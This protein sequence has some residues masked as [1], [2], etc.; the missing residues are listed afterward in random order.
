MGKFK[1]KI[2]GIL[3]WE[4]S[5]ALLLKPG[6]KYRVQA[7]VEAEN[8]EP[9]NIAVKE[10]EIQLQATP[11]SPQENRV[12]LATT[13]ITTAIIPDI[14]PHRDHWVSNFVS[15]EQHGGQ[16]YYKLIEQG[17][18]YRGNLIESVDPIFTA[19]D[20]G[21]SFCGLF[22]HLNPQQPDA[23]NFFP[24]IQGS[25]YAR[26]I[27][28]LDPKRIKVD[29]EFNRQSDKGYIFHD[30][31]MAFR[32]AM[33]AV[34][35]SPSKTLE[36]QDGKTYVITEYSKTDLV[37]DFFLFSKNGANLKIGIEDFFS[38]SE[39][40]TKKQDGCLFD[41]GGNSVK[42][43]I[44]NVNFLPPHR[45]VKSA[46]LFFTSLF[47]SSP[48]RDQESRV[49]VINMDSAREANGKDAR[50][51][52]VGFGYGFMYSSERGN[53]VIGKNIKHRGPGFMDFKANFGG[54]LYAVFENV[55][56]D[57]QN[58]ESFAS[59]RLKVKGKLENNIFIITSGH[60]IYEIY[61]Y[62]FGSGNV[63]HLLHL[64]RFTFIIDGKKAVIN[65]NQFKVRPFAKGTVKLKIRDAQSIYAKT[66]ELHAGDSLGY[67]G[68][69][70]RIVEKTRT[71]VTEWMQGDADIQYAMC[72]KL[73]Q[74]LPVSSGFLDFEVNSIGES[75]NNGQETEAFLIYKGNYEFRTFPN[76][77][78][79]DGEVLSSDPVGH[80]SYNHKEITLWAK[81]FKHKG[82]Y[83]QSLSHVG[84]SNGYT[85][86]GSEGF[87]GQFGPDVAVKNSGEMPD[88]AKRIIEDLEHKF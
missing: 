83:R 78:F 88:E 48:N 72:L 21:K 76:T 16:G 58:E 6:E 35:L 60:T 87:G 8:D 63:C 23:D 30:N 13:T 80:L 37:S 57:F 39:T 56:T 65:A 38:W 33:N 59:P 36:L 17:L 66:V 22:A 26:V 24:G 50:Y 67:Q 32:S 31:S 49:A 84:Q 54:G 43:G 53:Y 41:F 19:E 45:R 18:T 1:F 85:L 44:I 15:L 34:K 79:G 14:T 12:P 3:Q 2:E 9:A 20:V 40:N 25:R 47:K 51:N 5:E 10:A 27:E 46:Q 28:V 86:I 11:E 29:F 74:P 81:N 55:E 71:Y 75:L 42:I 64:G 77:Q 62:D 73:D 82:F 69:T 7:V 4:S 68:K 70:Y 61:T 52:Q